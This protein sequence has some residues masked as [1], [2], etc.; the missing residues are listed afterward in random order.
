M[1]LL[2]HLLAQ[3]VDYAGLFPPA[4][5]D[6]GTVVANYGRYLQSS[7]RW[8]LS[9]III[10]AGRLDEFKETSE[11]HWSDEPWLVSALVPSVDAPEDGFDRAMEA[12][13]RFNSENSGAKVDAIEIKCPHVSHVATLSTNVPNEIQAFLEIPHQTD[14]VESVQAIQSASGLFAKIRTGGV[15][16]E[17][18]P[19]VD[20]VARFLVRCAES[21]VGFKATAGLHHP[22][23]NEFNLT[24]L[25]D[26]DRAVMH[27]FLNVFV[28]GA[29]AFAGAELSHVVEILETTSISDFVLT[30]DGIQF[31]TESI[32]REQII[33]LRTSKAISFGS[34][35]FEEP[36]DDL[37]ALGFESELSTTN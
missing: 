21:Q 3:I 32:S 14:P 2:H 17:L 36:V 29:F 16:P 37:R 27:G 28:A 24:Y 35:S 20:E 9:R 26:S 7:E 19:S 8:M 23:R 18:I 6:M 4:G 10:P 30:T 5:L 25:P 13:Q 11:V 33:D 12:I 1:A 31:G 34:C 22:I 15:T